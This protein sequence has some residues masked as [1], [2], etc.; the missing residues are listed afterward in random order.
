MPA[1][2]AT[3]APADLS[4]LVRH[5]VAAHVAQDLHPRLVRPAADLL[6]AE[7]LG[8]DSLTLMEIANQAEDRF[9]VTLSHCDLRSLRTLADLTRFIEH[10]LARPPQLLPP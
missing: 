5:L 4:A 8:L 3:I 10:E 7:H 2:L 6:L 1:A 9:A